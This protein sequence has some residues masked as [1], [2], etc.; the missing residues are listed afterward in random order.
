MFDKTTTF[1]LAGGQGQ[2]L[3][4]LTHSIA[5]PLLPFGGVFR[6]IDFTLSNCRNSGLNPV[7]LLTQF[8][9][10]SVKRYIDGGA[11]KTG[12]DCLP[13]PDG[14]L[15]KGTA[16]AVI[17]NKHLVDRTSPELILILCADH[18]YKMD[19]RKLLRFH[20]RNGAA[21][22]VAAVE[23]P[24]EQSHAFGVI[25]SDPLGRIIGFEEKPKRPK[26]MRQRSGKA[27]ISMG[28]YVF[29]KDAL[30]TG[31]RECL[32]KGGS[33]FGRDLIP[34]MI[35]SHR[36][37]AYNF[38][39]HGQDL[40]TYWRDVGTIDT[41]HRSQMEVLFMDGLFDLSASARWPIHTAGPTAFKVI[42]KDSFV[43]D[44]VIA[45]DA[46]TQGA[47]VSRSIV[48]PG[49][50]LGHNAQVEDSIIMDGAQIG[51]CAKLKRV[52]VQPGGMV[53]RNARIG[54][55]S[56]EDSEQFYVTAGGTAVVSTQYCAERNELAI[57]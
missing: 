16:D 26:P 40:G 57:A 43:T 1:V 54:F 18:V 13:C 21:A 34:E 47:S 52:I 38:T 31:A 30:L 6:I 14:D 29:S 25:E 28:V 36:V 17:R 11:W 46:K 4:P 5:K 44:S 32:L 45:D 27:L 42:R 50:V 56:F 12:F 3:H 15:Y 22:T 8:D 35:Q 55:D 10:E 9:A 33:D 23:Y 20:T 2:R 19:Y 49:V 37:S 41:Y 48:G 53:D 39:E 7:H 24:I 51:Q